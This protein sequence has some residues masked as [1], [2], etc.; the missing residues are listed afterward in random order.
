MS[1]AVFTSY[2]QQL[3]DSGVPL[4]GGSV[5]VSQ[6]GTSTPITLKSASDLSGSSAANP[7]VLDSAGRHDMRY[8]ATQ[9][10]KVIVKNS[11]GVTVFT[12]DN[13]DP[14][15]AIGT[16]DVAIVDGGTGASTAGAAL[17]AL[18]G[19]TAASVAAIAADVASLSGTLA[20]SEKTHIATGTTG[21]RPASPIDGDI[22]KNTTTARYEVVNAALT[23]ENLVT[24]ATLKADIQA[25]TGPLTKQ[26]LLSGTSATYT[27][28]TDCTAI[29]V[30]MI[31]GGGGGGAATTNNGGTGGTTTFNSIDAAGG[32]GGGLGG[33]TS[34]GGAGGTGGSGS[35][36][37]RL[38]GSSGANGQNGADFTV[39]GSNGAPGIFG[40]GAGRGSSGTGGAGG[41]NTGAG[42]A[43]GASTNTA[44]GGGAGE[45]VEIVIT[46]P[47]TTYT[48]TVGTAGA[49]GAAG[50]QAGGAGGTGLIIVEEFYN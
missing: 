7:I 27:R 41:T 28:P 4:A 40:T 6:A 1:V 48:Y 18:G 49:A 5:T 35:A 31:G 38:P 14:G 46:S 24:S 36:S 33:T 3:N 30:K 42:G 34:L 13:I 23:Y 8:F 21:Q 26:Y 12:R 16:G 37:L 10:Y 43:G 25:L 44:G 9:A 19:A 32:G 2:G 15:I 22:R 45:Y 29:V 17:T 11:A 50:G 39:P 47:S 20:S